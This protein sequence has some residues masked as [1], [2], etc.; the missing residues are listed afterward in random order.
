MTLYQFKTLEKGHKLETLCKDGVR[1]ME[2]T[3]GHYMITLY[4]I[5]YFYVEVYF[6]AQ[7]ME[8]TKLHAFNT[9]L[10]LEPYLEQMDIS[11]LISGFL[12]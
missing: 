1:L 2:R 9:T 7:L 12:K 11:F 4:Q 3:V 6:D 8:I 10:L 5:E